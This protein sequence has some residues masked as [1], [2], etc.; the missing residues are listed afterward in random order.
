MRSGDCLFGAGGTIRSGACLF[1]AAGKEVR[2]MSSGTGGCG[3]GDKKV[4][5]LGP[6]W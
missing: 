2:V 3:G 4:C 6:C 5:A 1:G